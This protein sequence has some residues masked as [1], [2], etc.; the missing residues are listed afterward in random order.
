MGKIELP[1]Q[2]SIEDRLRALFKMQD[3]DITA[4]IE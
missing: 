4:L 3:K 2:V 1:P